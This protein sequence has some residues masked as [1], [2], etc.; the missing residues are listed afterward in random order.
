MK[1]PLVFA[2]PKLLFEKFKLWARNCSKSI[3]SLVVSRLCW[4]VSFLSLGFVYRLLSNQCFF[5]RFLLF[6]NFC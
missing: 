2:A 1:G 6:L 5:I 3:R 4:L